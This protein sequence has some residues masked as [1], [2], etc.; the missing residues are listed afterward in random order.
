MAEKLYTEAQVCRMIRD[1][2]FLRTK[3]LMAHVTRKLHSA[4]TLTTQQYRPEDDFPSNDPVESFDVTPPLQRDQGNG[5]HLRQDE[6]YGP[7]NH[8]LE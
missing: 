4:P 3:R 8:P 5:R 1:E 2:V 6:G 7:S